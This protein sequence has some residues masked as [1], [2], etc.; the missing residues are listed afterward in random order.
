MV[1]HKVELLSKI[2]SIGIGGR[3]VRALLCGHPHLFLTVTPTIYLTRARRERMRMGSVKLRILAASSSVAVVTLVALGF[4]STGTASAQTPDPNDLG[5]P[6][7][8]LN[9]HSVPTGCH[10]TIKATKEDGTSYERS[11]GKYSCDANFWLPKLALGSYLQVRITSFG[12]YGSDKT[13]GAYV[14]DVRN[15]ELNLTTNDT[16]MCYLVKASGKIYF[17]GMDQKYDGSCHG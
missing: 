1:G 6:V 16:A 12:K 2:D 5:G 8:F 11:S 3:S 9:R 10:V 4:A 17:T 14:S 15:Q 13:F 7:L